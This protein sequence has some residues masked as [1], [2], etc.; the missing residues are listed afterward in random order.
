MLKFIKYIFLYN[1]TVNY[2]YII[3]LVT[4]K[5]FSRGITLVVF[6]NTFFVTNIHFIKSLLFTA[7]ISISR[8]I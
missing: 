5:L 6:L 3:T 1:I 8:I 2:S 7:S 4:R